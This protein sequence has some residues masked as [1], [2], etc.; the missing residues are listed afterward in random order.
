MSLCSRV[1]AEEVWSSIRVSTFVCGVLR[2]YDRKAEWRRHMEE[3]RRL[4]QRA[5]EDRERLV[6][7]N[8]RLRGL[9]NPNVG[10]AAN[11]VVPRGGRRFH[12]VACVDVG[13]WGC[14]YVQR[15]EADFVLSQV[16]REKA[17]LRERNEVRTGHGR[18]IHL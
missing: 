6:N 15:A 17:S 2:R 8:H 4:I 9:L 10:V 16:E 18:P 3:K 11:E 12:P 1:M 13:W 7:E 14:A 5:N